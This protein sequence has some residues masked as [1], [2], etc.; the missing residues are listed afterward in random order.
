MIV[1]QTPPKYDRRIARKFDAIVIGSGLGGLVAG[2]RMSAAGRTVLV[3]EKNAS[4]GGSA[5][6]YVSN[7]VTI[8]A[9]LHELDGL[10]DDDPKLPTLREL[11]LTESLDFVEVGDLYEARSPLLDEPFA[12]PAGRERAV[13][14]AQARFPRHAKA[15]ASYLETLDDV[16][17]VASRSL[18]HQ[19][20]RLWWALNGPRMSRR[21]LAL[22]R[23][24]RRSFGDV[25]TRLFGDDEAVK[26][27]LAANVQYYSSDP[28]RLW[29]PF[30]AIGQG[31]YLA[32]GGHYVR[33]GSSVLVS[34]LVD[35]ITAGGGVVEPRRRVT[36][37]ALNGGRVSAV[38]HEGVDG[39]DG[40]RDDTPVVLANTA[41]HNLVGMLPDGEGRAVAGHYGH[42]PLS[43]ALWSI[44]VGFDRPPSEF[45][46]RSYSTW[47][48]PD[49]FRSLSDLE[50]SPDLLKADPDG[51]LPHF[52]IADYSRFD[53]GLPAPPYTASINGLDRID[54]WEGLTP[55]QERDRRERWTE[56]VL[57]ELDRHFP[58]LAASVVH[59]EM[60]TSR[61]AARYLGTPKGVIYGFAPH[62]PRRHFFRPRTPVEGLYLASA[63]TGFGGYSGSIVGGAQAARAALMG[64]RGPADT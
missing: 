44:G 19:D 64:R 47:I 53:S 50:R 9:S 28:A 39:D 57:R 58:G 62:T 1:E 10:D 56:R 45:G 16:R 60:T 37:I 48:F 40:A 24:L 17:T 33:G 18:I 36:R 15:I 46:V 3:L 25:N 23:N 59:A 32:G 26:L 54:V 21:A 38:E 4:L 20:D 52:I 51:R 14:A 49:W 35:L 29:F 11:G 63:W 42:R 31:S 2:A 43:L 8:E 30:F 61:S 12:L 27:A 13:A 34:A 41:P 7:G 55:E 22:V 6:T 5:G